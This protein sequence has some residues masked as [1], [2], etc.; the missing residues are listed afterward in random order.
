MKL[1]TDY[2][3]IGQFGSQTLLSVNSQ[4]RLK[5][6]NLGSNTV[7][8]VDLQDLKAGSRYGPKPEERVR[9]LG[10]SKTGMEKKKK[11]GGK[12]TEENRK[13]KREKGRE[14]TNE[15]KQAMV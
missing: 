3:P 8:S 9:P 6:F 1:S 13:K 11:G 7:N 5:T 14:V 4:L 10:Y 12:K 15:V 2:G